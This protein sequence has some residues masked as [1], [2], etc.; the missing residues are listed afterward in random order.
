MNIIDRIKNH[1]KQQYNEYIYIKYGNYVHRNFKVNQYCN[2]CISHQKRVIWM[3]ILHV[4]S[5]KKVVSRKSKCM[6]ER[7]V[8]CILEQVVIV[9]CR[10]NS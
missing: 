3:V 1:E 2:M 4:I 8:Y 5:I 7:T 6:S 10:V 9:I